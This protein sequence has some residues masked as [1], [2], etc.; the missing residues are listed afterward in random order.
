MLD[1]IGN[2]TTTF[3]EEKDSNFDKI[4]ILTPVLFVFRAKRNVTLAEI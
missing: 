2:S 1:K 4:L 3:E